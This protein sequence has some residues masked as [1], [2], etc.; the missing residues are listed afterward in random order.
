MKKG[1]IHLRTWWGVRTNKQKNDF[2]KKYFENT[3]K[4]TVLDNGRGFEPTY[5]VD[6]TDE[7]LAIIAKGEGID[8]SYS[9]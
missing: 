1:K 6:E 5:F 9:Y 2:K 7:N 4:C 3:D 8:C